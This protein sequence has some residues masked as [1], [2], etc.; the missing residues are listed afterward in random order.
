M[1]RTFLIILLQQLSYDF[2]IEIKVTSNS[3]KSVL[4]QIDS[5]TRAIRGLQGLMLTSYWSSLLCL[6][7]HNQTSVTA[8]QQTKRY[9]GMIV[10][11]FFCL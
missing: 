3:N 8:T 10:W 2:I 7:I 9:V 11:L 1:M 4:L 5:K 6:R